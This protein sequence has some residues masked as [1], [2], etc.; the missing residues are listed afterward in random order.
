MCQV[1]EEYAEEKVTAA[2]KKKAVETAIKA[3]RKNLSD[4]DVIDLSG[5][6]VEEVSELR[7]SL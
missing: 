4:E 3:I 6:T 1:V 5:L 7:R 2:V